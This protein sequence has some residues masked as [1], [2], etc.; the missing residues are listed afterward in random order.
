MFDKAANMLLAVPRF[1]PPPPFPPV[2]GCRDEHLGIGVWCLVFGGWWWVYGDEG[3]WFMVWCSGFRVWCL[4]FGVWC[5]VF[6][7]WCLVFG[8]WCLGTGAYG[9]WFMV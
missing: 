6:G 3:L 7:V 4:V 5:L 2:F 1:L 8:V 9:L